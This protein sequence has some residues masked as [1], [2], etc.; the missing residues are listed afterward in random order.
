MINLK[1]I[2][3]IKR[4]GVLDEKK[5]FQDIASRCNYIDE[6]AVRDFYMS[7]VRTITSSLRE[8]GVVRLPHL[9]DLALVKQKDKIGISGRAYGVMVKGAHM[10]KF[11]PSY[12]I[13]QYFS[14]WAKTQPTADPKEK[15]LEGKKL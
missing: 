3:D 9:G 1:G 15:L 8:N 4:T 5:F 10:L 14:E 7:M 6:S 12:A 2:K 11:Y 13:K